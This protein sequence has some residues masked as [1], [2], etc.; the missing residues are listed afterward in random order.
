MQISDLLQVDKSLKLISGEGGLDRDIS[1]VS[2]MDAPDVYRWMRGGEF[3]V[4]SGYVL[5]ESNVNLL[6]L[7]QQLYEVGISGFGIKIERY[8]HAL[9]EDVIQL[10][11]ELN[12]PIIGIPESYGFSQ[13]INTVLTE[14]L[15][16]KIEKL[17]FSADT[18]TKFTDIVIN[19]YGIQM[20]V[21]ALAD[22]IGRDV[23]F[24]DLYFNDEY[25]S[26]D[27]RPKG[28]YDLDE[29]YAVKVEVGASLFGELII[30]DTPENI[31]DEELIAI[32]HATT[33]IK[34]EMQ[35]MISNHQINRQY[36]DQYVQDIIFNNI[37]TLEEM[38][39]RALLYNK[40]KN[41]NGVVCVIID[42]DHYQRTS[43][44]SDK[45][46]LRSMNHLKE[47]VYRLT[48]ESLKA[49]VSH[50]ILHT[51]IGEHIIFLV[52]PEDTVAFMKKLPDALREV[53]DCVD[54]ASNL[55]VTIG[56]GGY[57]ESI[58]QAGFSYS[59]AKEALNSTQFNQDQ[60]GIIL[61]DEIR[62]YKVLFE[63]SQSKTA[64]DFIENHLKKLENYDMQ[65]NSSLTNTLEYLIDNNW[66][67]RMTAEALYLH[68][69]TIK[70]R[71][72]KIEAILNVDLKNSNTRFLFQLFFILKSIR[73][74]A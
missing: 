74:L 5:K 57:K 11:N 16:E 4:T 73:D 36:L 29:S 44:V 68:P 31:K 21:N 53:K 40:E 24:K 61:Y 69:N 35:K 30:L 20:I 23:I 58:L 13:I 66:N 62:Y 6:E 22:L 46:I 72:E 27:F 14:L 70:Y 12:L 56:V 34:L 32:E 45:N 15:D 60:D 38:D 71:V 19:G 9:T 33:V 51:T 37:E 67:Y 2:V 1:T 3:L 26:E 41:V 59:E 10:S 7:I 65:S 50:R 47:K 28:E 52:E 43:S 17:R 18:H 64:S 54:S 39:N 42:I 63:M 8:I 55:T 48:I 49:K 25:C